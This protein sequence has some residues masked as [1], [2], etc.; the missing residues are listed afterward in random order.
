M[1]ADGKHSKKKSFDSLED[2]YLD[3]IAGENREQ[4][5]SGRLSDH[6]AGVAGS[7]ETATDL[8]AAPDNPIRDIK[9]WQGKSLL[10]AADR[11]TLSLAIAAEGEPLSEERLTLALQKFGITHGIDLHALRE[12]ERAS[13][14]PAA[15]MI[16]IAHGTPPQYKS[17]FSFS[18]LP[19]PDCPPVSPPSLTAGHSL[20]FLQL[21]AVLH[22]P[23]LASI[24]IASLHVKALSPRECFLK[25]VDFPS[26]RPGRNVFGQEV[27]CPD[28]SLPQAGENVLFNEKHQ[29]YEATLYG[30]LLV[31]RDRVSIA[32]PIWIRPDKTAAC[33]IVLP[34]INPCRYPTVTEIRH[35]LQQMGIDERCINTMVLDKMVSQMATGSSLPRVI[36]VA[37]TLAPQHGRNAVFTLF[38]DAEKKAGKILHNDS[39]D[40]RERNAVVSIPAGTLVAEKQLAT[41]GKDGCTL[42]GKTIKAINGADKVI[43]VGQGVRFLKKEDR[44]QY[45]AERN[46]NVKFSAN[47]LAVSDIYAINGDIDYHSGNID[48][49]TDLLISGSV[50]SGF[51]VKSEGDITIQGFIEAGATV[52]AQGNLTVE[53]G[54]MGENTTVI[55]RG[56]LSAG[57]IQDAEV[58]AKGDILVKS[59]LFNAM[60]MAN[61]ALTVL[62]DRSRRSGSAAG[63]VLCSARAVKLSVIGSPGNPATIVAI[64]PDPTVNT[65]LRKLEE[66]KLSC[67]E[68]IA[69]ISRSLPFDATSPDQIKA[70]LAA[71]SVDKRGKI[72]TLLTGLSKMIKHHKA[73]L[74]DI[75]SLRTAIETAMNH[76]C[77]HVGERV[78]PS[79]EIHIGDKKLIVATEIG[80]SLFRLRDGQIVRN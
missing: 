5:K 23:D 25:I 47:T 39:I 77:I 70:T 72:I 27:E 65:Q 54:I 73:V 79:S 63:G 61:G 26:A 62:K 11:M 49:K 10:L 32:P 78:Y 13:R 34:Q 6:H 60:V 53:K 75:A 24:Q 35:I 58:I 59:Y 22:A 20:D 69:K 16:A 51:S 14:L 2:T 17:T 42:F 29:G 38:V 43:T 48:I 68:N 31:V 71:A 18:F 66:E 28:V 57:F 41:K 30:Y 80:P 37:E 4:E 50:L 36:K 9:G 19:Q 45:I 7:D 33:Y 40:L 55:A 64:R 44:I 46:G 12:A 74:D 56:N 67:A 21:H 1:A 76:A 52:I 8:L 3:T 15:Q